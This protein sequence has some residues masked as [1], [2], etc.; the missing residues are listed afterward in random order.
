VIALRG[1]LIGM[2]LA[3]A[4]CPA[5]AGAPEAPF[6]PDADAPGAM[7]LS[8]STWEDRGPGFTVRVQ[9]LDEAERQA[10]L[11][12]IVGAPVDPFPSRPDEAPRY[13]T[14][15]LQIENAS[16]GS[17][18]F[19]PQNCWL[20]TNKREILYPIGIEGLR[21][22]HDL[23]GAEMAPAYERAKPGVLE[24]TRTLAPGQTLTGLLVYRAP[25]PKTKSFQLDIQFATA[26]GEIVRLAAPYRR[27]KP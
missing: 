4:L 15:L 6:V 23:V 20:M 24:D 13:L 7:R 22:S 2:G 3:L 19:Q 10:Y 16:G 17:L 27:V 11:K 18:E 8:R 5:A 14:F 26:D 1:R 12:E 21:T 25:L 9:R